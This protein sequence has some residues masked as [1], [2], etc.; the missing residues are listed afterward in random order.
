[1]VAEQRSI[2]RKTDGIGRYRYCLT[3]TCADPTGC[4]TARTVNFICLNPST[5]DA[6]T[7]DPTVRRLRGFTT[8]W[9]YDG[10]WLTNLFAYRATDP[11]DLCTAEGDIVGPLND[12]WLVAV[13]T[14]AEVVVAAW[15]AVDGLFRD[16]VRFAQRRAAHVQS[17][18][19]MPIHTMGIT[20]NGFPRHPLYLRGDT[21]PRPAFR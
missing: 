14:R 20:K 3:R 17:L 15:G 5:A 21:Q 4:R 12:T 9:G 16:S 7:D 8:A 1:M 6:T 2:L 10:F 13:A 18:L 11:M 19:P